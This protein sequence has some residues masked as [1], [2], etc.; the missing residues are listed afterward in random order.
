LRQIVATI[1]TIS[2]E[3]LTTDGEPCHD[4]LVPKIRGASL[5]EHRSLV[6]SDLLDVF[7]SMLE[8]CGYDLVQLPDV[9]SRA[10]IARNTIYNYVSDKSGL[11]EAA[12][13]RSAD[14]MREI[15]E[16]AANEQDTATQRLDAIIRTIVSSFARPTRS[17]LLLRA[18]SAAVAGA[19]RPAGMA[20]FVDLLNRIED[21]VSH[22]IN[23]GE[24]APVAD[25]TATVEFM[26]GAT[27]VA[28]DHATRRPEDA[29]AI[30]G[31]V[32]A[33]LIGALQRRP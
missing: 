33:F 10:G 22:G 11:L 28:V 4:V 21:I 32:S 20:P 15:I 31:Q 17:I 19:D 7:E 13:R 18:H 8:E 16:R 9:A 23:T 25:L 26:T 2:H 6:W 27:T 5:A 29:A 12:A 1:P 14:E 30:A 3:T 24:F